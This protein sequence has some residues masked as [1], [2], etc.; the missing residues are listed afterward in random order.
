[1]EQTDFS[2]PVNPE[3]SDTD[4][5]VASCCSDVSRFSSPVEG[6]SPSSAAVQ[7]RSSD[8]EDYAAYMRLPWEPESSD[9]SRPCSP[10]EYG[11]SESSPHPT[12]L[13]SC[14][15]SWLEW[16]P[17]LGGAIENHQVPL[18]S[19]PPEFTSSSPTSDLSSELGNKEGSSSLTLTSSSVQS[20]S[21]SISVSQHFDCELRPDQ[22][23]QRLHELLLLVLHD[24]ELERSST[25]DEETDSLSDDSGLLDTCTENFGDDDD[26]VVAK[27]RTSTPASCIAINS[28]IIT[29][30]W[31]SDPGIISQVSKQPRYAYSPAY[32]HY[33]IVILRINNLSDH[34]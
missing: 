34:P 13:L 4:N 21:A 31:F 7:L 32:M 10:R 27:T 19:S 18:S 3:L 5:W 15:P 26:S 14:P 16:Q 11:L 25:R 33:S 8:D 28:P 23:S 9:N 29:S 1:M 30:K 6:Y 20:D 2:F 22:F 12:T 17:Q 24:R